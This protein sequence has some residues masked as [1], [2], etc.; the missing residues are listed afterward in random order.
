MDR[1]HEI[2]DRLALFKTIKTPQRDSATIVDLVKMLKQ[3]SDEVADLPRGL[4]TVLRVLQ[5][6]SVEEP[7]SPSY[8]E[9]VAP[10]QLKYKFAQAEMFSADVMTH[11]IT[12]LQVRAPFPTHDLHDCAS[13]YV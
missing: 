12:I 5:W 8:V 3:H 1:V 4:I 11:F 10:T 2:Q 7:P 6:L 13:K 9:S